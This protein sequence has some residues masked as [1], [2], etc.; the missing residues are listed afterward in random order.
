MSSIAGMSKQYNRVS[1]E[2]CQAQKKALGDNDS[3]TKHGGFRQVGPTLAKGDV[4]VLSL[5]DDHDVNV[6]W[7][8]SVY[9]TYSNKPGSDRGAWR[10]Q[11]V[12]QLMSSARML[13]RRSS[14]P[15]SVSVPSILPTSESELKLSHGDCIGSGLRV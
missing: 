1:D 10:P 7:L 12:S 3:F 13:T 5:W 6:L 11:A 4:V 9:P 15:A 2:F 8:D 14:I